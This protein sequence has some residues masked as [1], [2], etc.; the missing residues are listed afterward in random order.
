MDY[1]TKKIWK[2]YERGDFESA[3]EILCETI[4]SDP[5]DG[6]LYALFGWLE[7]RLNNDCEKAIGFIKEALK[8]ECPKSYYHSVY[9]EYLLRMQRYEQAIVEYERSVKYEPSTR[10]Y[11]ALAEALTSIEDKRALDVWEEVLRRDPRNC[12]ALLYFARMSAKDEDFRKALDFLRRAE[13]RKSNDVNDL[14]EIGY[15][16]QQ[17]GNYNHALKY[18]IRAK[19]NGVQMG[20]Y[21]DALI[22]ICYAETGDIKNA[23]RFISKVKD[24]ESNSKNYDFIQESLEYCKKKLFYIAGITDAEKIYG[25]FSSALSIWPNDSKILAYTA[26]FEMDKKIAKYQ[27]MELDVPVRLLTFENIDNEIQKNTDTVDLDDDNE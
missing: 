5:E 12:K 27:P 21:F 8:H 26:S 3:Y 13:K 20:E 7:M 4:K 2:H 22:A 25:V 24:T 11:V 10:Y 23:L 16:Y 19:D 6:G 15:I 9:G 14:L 17:L 1:K 18:L